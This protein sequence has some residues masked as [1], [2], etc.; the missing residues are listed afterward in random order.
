ML[1]ELAL[2][3][4]GFAMVPEFL[5]HDHIK[6]GRLVHIHKSLYG[7][8]IPISVVMPEQKEVPM[9]VKKFSEFLTRQLKEILSPI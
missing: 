3:G 7:Q 6:S 9:R 8:E 1:L 4:K 2:L 5:C